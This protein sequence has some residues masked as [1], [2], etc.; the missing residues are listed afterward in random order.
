[1]KIKDNKKYQNS[2]ILFHS[3]TM[4]IPFL[5]L[6]DRIFQYEPFICID[7]GNILTFG[8]SFL[9]KIVRN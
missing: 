2:K 3:M 6:T 9:S 1:M 4:P 8:Y 7:N 5:E